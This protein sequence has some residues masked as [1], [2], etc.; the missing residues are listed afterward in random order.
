M[1]S[2]A[3]VQRE[4]TTFAPRPRYQATTFAEIERIAQVILDSGSYPPNC[5]NINK[6]VM[7]IL[8]G[9][10][11]GL[12][13]M[14]SMASITPPINGKCA[15]FGD[16]GLALV[17]ASGQLEVFVERIEGHGDARTAYTRIKR[18][19]FPEKEFA[20]TMEQAK[21]LKSYRFANDINPRTK[22]P[23]G[24]PWL[25]DPDN[26]LQWRAR[27]RAIRSEFTDVLNGM[28][29]VEEQEDGDINGDAITV[30]ATPSAT[31]PATQAAP[32]VPPSPPTPPA[33]TQGGK[34]TEQQIA[35][36]RRLLGLFMPGVEKAERLER[37][38]QELAQF[39]VDRGSELTTS[40]A[41]EFITLI[42]RTCDPFTY[43]TP[44]P[45]A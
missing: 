18:V 40:Q 4:G 3:I 31:Q 19:G 14:Q 13:P 11:I 2:G 37:W 15:L 24:G 27:W 10:D 34:A 32:V 8:A 25:D 20:Y 43:P 30:E 26:M 41:D 44:S 9:N 35:E 29:G 21:K 36:M 45:T 1:T 42:G 33:I 39:N 28:G 38:K 5:D 17:R 6:L 22:Q 12:S 7:M 16:M 23:G